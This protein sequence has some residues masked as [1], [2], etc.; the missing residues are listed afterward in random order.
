MKACFY[1][2]SKFYKSLVYF[3]NKDPCE[4]KQTFIKEGKEPAEFV[5]FQF[6]K[7]NELIFYG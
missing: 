6:F 5:N 2:I 4:V 1:Y 7:M 3:K